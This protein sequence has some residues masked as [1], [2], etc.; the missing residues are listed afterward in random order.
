MFHDGNM[1]YHGKVMSYPFRKIHRIWWMK[2]EMAYAIAPLIARW[3]SPIFSVWGFCLISSFGHTPEKHP[4]EN[5][6]SPLL[7]WIEP[8]SSNNFLKIYKLSFF[9]QSEE[10]LC[11]LQWIGCVGKIYFGQPHDD[12]LVKIDVS[13]RGTSPSFRGQ[14]HLN[15]STG[16]RWRWENPWVFPEVPVSVFPTKPIQLPTYTK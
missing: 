8:N 11:S 4:Y 14:R 10:S 13:P 1:I 16:S 15:V 9:V 3:P 5:H 7:M 6:A 12:H 2:T